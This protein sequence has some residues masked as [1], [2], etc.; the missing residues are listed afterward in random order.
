MAFWDVSRLQTKLESIFTGR[1]CARKFVPNPHGKTT[2]LGG[3]RFLCVS[4]HEENN[5]SGNNRIVSICPLAS[6]L[7]TKRVGRATLNFAPI[8]AHST[9]P[10]ALIYFAWCIHRAFI[11]WPMRSI[12]IRL[13][14]TALRG[15]NCINSNT[16]EIF[17][18]LS[19]PGHLHWQ[20]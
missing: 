2:S 8:T 13:M 14:Q 7:F 5:M 9:G 17:L 19:E 20:A 6:L 10:P 15:A 4:V 18:I 16:K 12:F 11:L 1:T 3:L